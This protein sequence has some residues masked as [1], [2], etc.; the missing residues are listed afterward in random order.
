MIR[1][2]CGGTHLTVQGH[3]GHGQPGQDIVCAAVSALVYALAGVLQEKGQLARGDIREGYADIAG[4]GD[5]AREFALVEE[6]Q[7]PQ[8]AARP[9]EGQGHSRQR[10]YLR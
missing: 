6:S 10:R 4:A 8:G 5:C 7:V 2:V 1:A 9:H 3:A